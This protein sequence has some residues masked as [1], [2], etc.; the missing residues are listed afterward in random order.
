[1]VL[2]YKYPLRA[3]AI[4]VALGLSIL[5]ACYAAGVEDPL[6]TATRFTGCASALLFLPVFIARPLVTIFGGARAGGLLRHR[7]GLGVALA[8]NHHVHMG[9]VAMVLVSDGATMREVIANPALYIYGLLI[10]MNVTSFPAIARRWPREAVRWV[11]LIG[12]YALAV[13][14]FETLVLSLITGAEGGVFR[15]G[16]AIAF[17]LCVLIR[18]FAGVYGRRHSHIS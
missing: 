2:P 7:A 11:H 1:M 15:F 16:Y 17:V 10:L 5:G 4:G 13:A 3:L 9:L 18:I 8:G 6:R 14:F 12:L